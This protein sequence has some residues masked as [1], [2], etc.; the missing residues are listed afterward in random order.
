MVGTVW[1]KDLLGCKQIERRCCNVAH[2]CSGEPQWCQ[3]NMVGPKW[4]AQ[5]VPG[6]AGIAAADSDVDCCTAAA[7]CTAALLLPLSAG[8]LA[9]QL[10]LELVMLE[11]MVGMVLEVVGGLHAAGS[12]GKTSLHYSRVVW[13][14]H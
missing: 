2:Q 12:E 13:H 1:Q 6:V 11:G 7:C 14:H 5:K 10:P 3:G 8:T 4:W 9:V